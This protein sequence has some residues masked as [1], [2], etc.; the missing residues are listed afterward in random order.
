MNDEVINDLYNRAKALGY[1]KERE[2]FLSLLATNT[3]VFDD[4]FDYVQKQ[5]YKKDKDAFAELIG[6]KKKDV[7]S[8]TPSVS[9]AD[10]EETSAVSPFISVPESTDVVSVDLPEVEPA[11]FKGTTDGRYIPGPFGRIVRSVPLIGN[12]IDTTFGMAETSAY[13][14]ASADE[15]FRT[16][17][18]KEMTQQEA[19]DLAFNLQGILDGADLSRLQEHQ[20]RLANA[21]GIFE[22]IAV[23]LQDADVSLAN[24]VSSGV[25]MLAT[26]ENET[27]R[28]L[29]AVGAGVGAATGAAFGATALP[30][31]PVTAPAGAISGSVY[32]G[33]SALGAVVDGTSTSIEILFEEVARKLGKQRGELTKFDINATLVQEIMSDE[34]TLRR[35]RANIMGRSSSL[36][37][38]GALTGGLVQAGVKQVGRKALAEGIF[39]KAGVERVAQRAAEIGVGTT[40]EVAG[41]AG[42]EIAAQTTGQLAEFGEVRGIETAAVIEEAAAPIGL[43]VFTPRATSKVN[44]RIVSEV[45]LESF[46]EDAT[47]EEF[48]KANIEVKD[49]PELQ[50][51][52]RERFID[53][54]IETSLPTVASESQRARLKALEMRRIELNEQVGGTQLMSDLRK[55]ELDRINRDIKK[56]AEEI[57]VRKAQIS[58]EPEAPAPTAEPTPPSQQM[59]LESLSQRPE[60]RTVLNREGKE[61]MEGVVKLHDVE[62]ET[63]VF[64]SATEI[65]DLGNVDEV[66]GMMND[67]FGIS[68]EVSD[69]V[70]RPDGKVE[71]AG[72]VF[73]LQT[74]LPTRGVEVDE[75]GNVTRVSLRRTVEEGGVEVAPETQMFEGVQAEEIAY[76]INR[77]EALS[78]EQKV[79]IA[80]AA[81]DDEELT[82]QGQIEKRR[83]KPK[84]KP[85]PEDPAVTPEEGV[86]EVRAEV[87]EAEPTKTEQQ[88]REELEA[89]Q[90]EAGIKVRTSKLGHL[91]ER[92]NELMVEQGA[93]RRLL[94]ANQ[95]RYREEATNNLTAE[96]NKLKREF[97]QFNRLFNNAFFEQFPGKKAKDRR[98]SGLT[99]IDSFLRGKSDGEVL[100][101]GQKTFLKSNRDYIDGFIQRLLDS[102]Y[103]SNREFQLLDDKGKPILDDKGKP[104]MGSLEKIFEDSKGNYLTRRYSRPSRLEETIYKAALEQ[105]RKEIDGG[106]AFQAQI[107]QRMADEGVDRKTAINMIAEQKLNAVIRNDQRDFLSA[108]SAGKVD[109]S[110]LKRRGD[111]PAAFRAAMGEVTDPFTNYANT[112][113]TVTQMF[114]KEKMFANMRK[115]GEGIYFFEEGRVPS[116]QD[117]FFKVQIPND[118]G[119]GALA[120]M[121]TS[122][123][124]AADVVGSV[125]NKRSLLSLGWAKIL[126]LAKWAKTVGSIGTHVLNFYGNFGFVVANGHWGRAKSVEALS[127]VFGG[128]KKST[129]AERQAL[130]D[131]LIRRGVIRQSVTL[132]EFNRFLKGQDIGA[133]FDNSVMETSRNFVQAAGKVRRKVGKGFEAVYQ[134]T[135]DFFKIFGYLNDMERYSKAYYGKKPSELTPQ[136]LAELKDEIADQTK[137]S[138]PDYSRVYGTAQLASRS[139]F[140]GSFVS[141]TAESYRVGINLFYMGY[142]DLARGI[143]ERNPRLIAIGSERLAATAAVISGKASIHASTAIAAGVGVTG[144]FAYKDSNEEDRQKLRDITPALEPW[145]A[146]RDGR[147][148]EWTVPADITIFKI[149]DGEMTYF[150]NSSKDAFGAPARAIESFFIGLRGEGKQYVEGMPVGDDF[151]NGYIQMMVEALQPFVA[152]DFLFAEAK[153]IYANENNEYWN[154]E[155]DVMDNLIKV[156]G[157][158]IK[159]VEPGTI[160]S[161]RR[162]DNPAY[163]EESAA[164]V[165]LGFAPRTVKFSEQFFYL[166]QD[167]AS[168]LRSIRKSDLPIEDKQRRIREVYDDVAYIFKGFRRQ[169][170]EYN[171][172]MSNIP[173]L[174]K[175]DLLNAILGDL[176]RIT[177]T[178]DD[179]PKEKD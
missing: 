166:C 138:Y 110:S 175:E 33:I 146:T 85:Q 61:P 1:R 107:A 44:G 174:A 148:R 3:Q 66:K 177:Y 152:E 42:T 2:D 51:K 70:A 47:N 38:F 118:P 45:D 88:L 74:D 23:V 116:G 172:L 14:G 46:I 132:Q 73:E 159:A 153:K 57:E 87:P 27:G 4:N 83:S 63:L 9:V 145:V 176:N 100:S 133:A 55:A 149:G 119:Y 120:G 79:E 121:Y 80:Q 140:V 37:V 108:A 10:G 162:L 99:E 22:E 150:N 141:Y 41:G 144:L 92:I 125:Q 56:I 105:G 53:A 48:L 30:L 167:H 102:G 17:F 136:Q 64:E 15:V 76:Q 19:E 155:D 122:P 24:I 39:K 93:G 123:S 81:F 21:N 112:V 43:A 163:S 49:N 8:L 50:A 131:D 109:K 72:D 171:E 139:P 54:D 65:V 129:R 35:M 75:D 25:G 124:M 168:Q 28:G 113:E 13:T 18:G 101:L 59:T 128:W 91:V 58:P 111:I 106:E 68:F 34:E 84:R 20:R 89:K 98:E 36:Y 161:I 154:P 11:S 97:R 115:A 90:K 165:L 82:R 104:M 60:V 134:G 158:F 78:D 71:V 170:S 143:A 32:G 12:L 156:A 40:I 178:E 169:G 86:P 6:V 96:A 130:L 147:V 137:N 117:Q 62:K 7:P 103:I 52:V 173:G 5:G 151:I 67:E 69:V 135:D 127:T 95:V 26:L 94:T 16:A 164:R 29:G 157:A 160:T 179:E 31:A 142:R 126:R 77:Y 114:Y